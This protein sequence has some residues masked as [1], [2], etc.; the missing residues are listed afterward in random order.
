[1][2]LYL[3]SMIFHEIMSRIYDLLITRQDTN[4]PGI[5]LRCDIHFIYIL[6]MAVP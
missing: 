6:L 4:Q 1:M 5:H 2:K 3:E